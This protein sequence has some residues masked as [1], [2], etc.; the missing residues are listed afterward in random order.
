MGAAHRD[1]EKP[2]PRTRTIQLT[3]PRFRRPS[4]LEQRPS[5]RLLTSDR[6]GGYS[7]PR[8]RCGRSDH[9]I[10][11]CGRSSARAF[12]CKSRTK[13]TSLATEFSLKTPVKDDWR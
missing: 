7:L 12:S 4:E 1:Q 6:A 2:E 5:C 3:L 9:I 8:Y 11:A 10:V 13:V